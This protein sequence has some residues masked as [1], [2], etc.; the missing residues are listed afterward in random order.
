M[1]GGPSHSSFPSQIPH[2]GGSVPAAGSGGNGNFS[3][4]FQHILME[5]ARL[6]S[7]NPYLPPGIIFILILNKYF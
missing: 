1:G 6:M 5:T 2:F 3:T 4:Y 7:P